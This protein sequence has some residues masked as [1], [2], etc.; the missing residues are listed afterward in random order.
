VDAVLLEQVLCL[1]KQFKKMKPSD[2]GLT[3]KKLFNENK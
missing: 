1:H 3:E 2:W